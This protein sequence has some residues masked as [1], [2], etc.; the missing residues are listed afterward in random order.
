MKIPIIHEIITR[1]LYQDSFCG[2]LSKS[3][4]RF[5]LR[6]IYRMPAQRINS[7]I[8]EM[9]ELN[10]VKIADIKTII[11]AEPNHEGRFK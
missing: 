11:V 4:A 5:L 10:L 8:S 9:E 7:I 2:K 1:R 6:V 3:R